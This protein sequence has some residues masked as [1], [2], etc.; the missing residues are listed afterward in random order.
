MK[1]PAGAPSFG[2]GFGNQIF[3]NASSGGPD[4]EPEQDE[5]S[6]SAPDAEHSSDEDEDEDD[7]GTDDEL[8]TAMASSTLD[9]SEWAT[10]PAY[11]TLYLSTFSEYL[12]K[13]KASKVPSAEDVE[14]DY[15][16]GKD[17][18]DTSWAMEG[19]E[20]S[21][22]TDHVFDRFSQRVEYQSDQCVRYVT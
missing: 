16:K 12:P 22:E 15:E 19:Y 11:T 4:E 17:T 20:N 21:L 6:S 10:A 14:A 3:G 7:S 2:S 5:P 18:K 8:I 13:P 9:T 1:S